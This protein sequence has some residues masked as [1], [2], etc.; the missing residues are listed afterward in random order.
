MPPTPPLPSTPPSQPFS[1]EEEAEGGEDVWGE[2]GVVPRD[3]VAVGF[4]GDEV[5][6]LAGPPVPEEEPQRDVLAQSDTG[7]EDDDEAALEF[8]A[9]D[10]AADVRA[11]AADTGVARVHQQQEQQLQ[12][13]RDKNA[14]PPCGCGYVGRTNPCAGC[15]WD[16]L[17][18]PWP[19]WDDVPKG[20]G[21][22][23]GKGRGRR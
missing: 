16:S 14:A 4:L 2:E 13:P 17:L 8:L 6:E 3:D 22:R 5:V 21:K 20:R 12:R 9:V 1:P 7:D 19:G 15:G 23:K 11:G 10:F 18:G